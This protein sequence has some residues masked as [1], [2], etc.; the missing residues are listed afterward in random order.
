MV[1]MRAIE[2]LALVAGEDPMPG[3]I[4]ISNNSSSRIEVLLTMNSIAF[5]R[6]HHGFVLN[7]K[8]FSISV[9]KGEFS[10]RLEYFAGE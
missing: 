3:L 7:P 5:F 2:A 8:S 6:D 4:E 1:R 9:P 10:R